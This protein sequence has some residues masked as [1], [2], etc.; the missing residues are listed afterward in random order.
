MMYYQN[1]IMTEEQICERYNDAVADLAIYTASVV[2]GDATRHEKYLRNAGEGMSQALEGAVKCHMRKY[3]NSRECSNAFNKFQL[4]MAIGDFYWDEEN[5]YE[6]DLWAKTLTENDSKVDFVFIK[7]NRNKL[8]ND[9]KHKGGIVELDV[10]ERYMQETALFIRDYIMQDAPLRTIS[11]Y[12]R[13][14]MDKALR[15]Y[16]TCDKFLMTELMFW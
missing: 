14:E 5:N 2:R 12:N 10:V 4:P 11:D 3:L 9:A 7:N 15:F 16:T 1:D 8:T 13:P 6:M